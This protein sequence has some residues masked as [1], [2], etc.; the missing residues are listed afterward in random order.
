LRP[1]TTKPK[2]EPFCST[3]SSSHNFQLPT[4][5][6]LAF[7]TSPNYHAARINIGG[8]NLGVYG[9][10]SDPLTPG[11][12]TFSTSV[13]INDDITF[14]G[15]ATDV[16]IIQIAGDLKQAGDKSV[17]LTGGAKEENIFWQVGGAVEVGAAGA[18]AEGVLLVKETV[19][20]ITGSSL[21]GRVLT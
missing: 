21:N 12:Y 11:V 14:S 16:F 18:H 19:T 17:S 15:S 1:R 8:G 10:A 4:S 7:A 9:D 3:L 20:F 6:V 13:S 5:T 2:S